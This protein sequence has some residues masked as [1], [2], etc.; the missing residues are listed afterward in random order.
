MRYLYR[1]LISLVV[2]F[3]A[4]LVNLTS[5]GLN[6]LGLE[7]A[8]SFGLRAGSVAAGIGFLFASFYK[9]PER[10]KELNT[11]TQKPSS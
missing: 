11:E 1:F 6:I 2:F 7:Y 8:L 10:K 9:K 3:L 5:V 4:V